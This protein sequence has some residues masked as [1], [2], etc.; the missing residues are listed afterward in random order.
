[1]IELMARHR[2]ASV[3][4][5]IPASAGPL[6]AESNQQVASRQVTVESQDSLQELQAS[7]PVLDHQSSALVEA[8][9]LMMVVHSESVRQTLNRSGLVDPGFV[10][11][12]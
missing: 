8:D 3:L 9:P 12:P 6:A 1:M 2:L 4:E 5:S 10:C 11:F 7:N